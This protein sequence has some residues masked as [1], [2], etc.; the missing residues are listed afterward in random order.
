MGHF[1]HIQFCR[2]QNDSNKEPCNCR[3]P[4]INVGILFFQVFSCTDDCTACSGGYL[5]GVSLF[6]VCSHISGP[7]LFVMRLTVGQVIVRLTIPEFSRPLP[8]LGSTIIERD[9]PVQHWL[10]KRLLQRH[11]F[12]GYPL[13]SFDCLSVV[14]KMHLYPL[15]QAASAEP[16]T[17]IAACAFDDA[18]QV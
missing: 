6:Q 11:G 13:F 7:C 12:S 17:G 3:S 1:I 9:L 15:T 5:P 4:I 16:A 2:F 8:A 18:R 14:V 10:G